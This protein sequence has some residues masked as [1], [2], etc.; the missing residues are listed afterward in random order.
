MPRKTARDRQGKPYRNRAG[1]IFLRPGPELSARLEKEARD[2]GET[3][4][5]TLLRIAASYFG[6]P[7]SAAERGRPGRPRRTTSPAGDD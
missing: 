6:L 3:R 1:L 2:E 5:Q 7:R 4:Q